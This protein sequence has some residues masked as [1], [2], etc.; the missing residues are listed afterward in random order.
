MS[1]LSDLTGR[2]VG[3]LTVVCREG[4]YQRPSGNKEPTWRCRCECG[5]EAVVVASNLKRKNTLSCGCL[6]TENRFGSRRETEYEIRNDIVYTKTFDGV[7]FVVNICDLEIVLAHRWHR[8]GNGYIA[9]EKGRTIHRILM[10]PPIEMDIHHINENKLNNRRS[11]L[12]RNRLNGYVPKLIRGAIFIA[13]RSADLKWMM[14][15]EQITAQTAEQR[16]EG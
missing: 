7:E 14:S 6:Q 9:D 2:K 12:F 16:C 8:N 10:K 3:R 15:C 4:T 1:K 13:V 5:N 11:N